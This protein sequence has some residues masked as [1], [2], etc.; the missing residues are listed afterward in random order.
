MFTRRKR[1]KRFIYCNTKIGLDDFAGAT[2]SEEQFQCI[3][4]YGIVK[5]TIICSEIGVAFAGNNIY[6]AAELFR[7]LCVKKVFTTQEVV[8][9]AYDIHMPY[10]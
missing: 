5:I 4:K 6:L 7:Q 3:N 8:D 9:M 1:I 2:F 10:Q